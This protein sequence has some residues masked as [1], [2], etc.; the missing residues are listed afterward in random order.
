M[1]HQLATAPSYAAL[2]AAWAAHKASGTANGGKHPT[3][4]AAAKEIQKKRVACQVELG[5]TVE[6]YDR[7][8]L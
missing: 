5:I 6:P 7:R 1:S 2:Q 3:T 8:W 4:V